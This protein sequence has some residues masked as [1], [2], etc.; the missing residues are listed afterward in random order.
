MESHEAA[1]SV[2]AGRYNRSNI[3]DTSRLTNVL[4]VDK[5]KKTALVEPNVA[6]DGFVAATLPFGLV[7]P[8]VME[9]PGI[10]AGGG[11]SGT[12][13]ESSSFKYGFFDRTVIRI[14][15]VLANGETVSASS[16]DKPDL[17]WGAA[18]SFGTLGVITLLEIQLV[19]AKSHVE[20]KY[21]KLSIFAKD[22][23]VV[24]SGR[25]VDTHG[26]EAPT[27]RFTRRRDPWFYLHAKKLTSQPAP[28]PPATEIVPLVDYLFRYDR[29]GFWV[30]M[31]A[32]KYFITPFNSITRGVLDKFMHTRVMYHA[33]H[34][35]GL[36]KQYII[37]DVAVSY[38]AADEFVDWLDG[39]VGL[40]PLWLCPLKQ[41]GQRKD[42]PHG[43]LAEAANAD[44]PE[45]LL[46]F[47]IWGPGRTDPQE[48]VDIN[49]RLEQ[50]V[51]SLGGNK[52]LYAHAY[53]TEDEFWSIFDR[54]AYDALRL[55][56]GASYLPSIYDKVKV[57]FASD[58]KAIRDSWLLWLV[59]I[60]WSIW[61]LQGLYGVYKA[62]IGGEYLLPKERIWKARALK[63]D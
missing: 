13:G 37:Q 30:G 19:E 52:W 53:Y 38:P 32:F 27:Q 26:Q 40:Y 56:Y 15:I 3:I 4:H 2:I 23:I 61:P 42:S 8:V 16:S 46:N 31:Y 10:T 54:K 41:R 55:K 33:L 24:C 17:F 48:F 45:Y 62:T 57:D 47:G 11:F 49:R 22:W 6:M 59:A 7:P 35:S 50:K 34:Q 36:S 51:N 9:F 39:N 58:E 25:L 12:S 63:E 21:H 28:D 1:V 18:A 44:T 5:E 14:Q 60:F 29:G 43:L 20:L